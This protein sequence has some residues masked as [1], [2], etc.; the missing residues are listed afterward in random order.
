MTLLHWVEIKAHRIKF[1]YHIRFVQE[2]SAKP[3]TA[4]SVF[5]PTSLTGCT[6]RKQKKFT[7]TLKT[8]K[9]VA[10]QD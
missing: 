3:A 10:I 9:L 7:A 5:V 8:Y 4:S 2:M 1:I 6:T